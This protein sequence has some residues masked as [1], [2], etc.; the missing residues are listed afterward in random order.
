[1]SRNACRADPY[2]LAP[3]RRDVR[4]PGR[5]SWCASPKFTDCL[6]REQ[7]FRG[8]MD[9]AG[10]ISGLPGRLQWP[11]QAFNPF[12]IQR[13]LGCLARSPC[14]IVCICARL[15]PLGFVET[16]CELLEIVE[17]KARGYDRL[18]AQV[19]AR[20]VDRDESFPSE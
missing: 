6:T 1:M 18:G 19:R 4:K 8:C 13:A 7:A 16:R 10:F 15:L 5:R 2:A 12:G 3:C 9:Q 11:H 20:F 14:A 17:R